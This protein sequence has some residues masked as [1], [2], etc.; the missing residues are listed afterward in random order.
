[1]ALGGSLPTLLSHIGLPD[2]RHQDH[3][4]HIHI[5]HGKNHHHFRQTIGHKQSTDGASD[6]KPSFEMAS[7]PKGSVVAPMAGLV[8]KVLVNDGQVVEEGQPVLV[9]EAMKMEVCRAPL[10]C[11]LL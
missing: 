1:M 6:H 8:V 7:H 4:K 11:M 10:L 2:L 5:W 9:L 3:V